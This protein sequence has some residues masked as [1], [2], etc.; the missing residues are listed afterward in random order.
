MRFRPLGVEGQKKLLA[1]RVLVCGCGALGSVSAELLARAGVGH[2]RIVDRDFLEL[3][4]LQRQ[5]LYDEADVASGLPKAEA[6]AR[7]LRSINSEITIEPLVADIGFKNVT[8]LMDG[9]DLVVDGTDNFETRFLLND[10][11][12]ES[13]VPWIFA[14]CLGA[15]GQTMTVIPEQSACL[16]CLMPDGPPDPGTMPTCDNAGILATIIAVMASIQVTEALKILVGQLDQVSRSLTVINLW[17]NQYRTLDTSQLRHQGP[18]PACVQGKRD[19]LRGKRGSHATV[20]C[21]RNAV[22]V[23]LSEES[24]FDLPAI[25]RQLPADQISLLNE[26]MLRVVYEDLRLTLFPDGRVIVNGTEDE[27]HAKSALA[28]VVGH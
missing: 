27:R 10:A 28:R 3:N 23:R 25:A 26:F 4:N 19:W 24:R 2:L 16:H 20:L 11:C 7:K 1:S 22:Q 17:D 8:T 13:H 18:C 9:C 15:E 12:L 5:S 6:A 14:G 21:G